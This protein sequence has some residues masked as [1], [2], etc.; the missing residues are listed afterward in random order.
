MDFYLFDFIFVA[1]LSLY[2]EACV[3]R[4]TNAAA[5]Q[6]RTVFDLKLFENCGRFLRHDVGARTQVYDFK[7]GEWTTG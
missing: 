7:R 2:G 3:S 1:L 4:H 6:M 5:L